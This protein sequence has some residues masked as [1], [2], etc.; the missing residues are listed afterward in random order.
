MLFIILLKIALAFTS[1]KRVSAMRIGAKQMQRP[2][3][4]IKTAE[5]IT[6]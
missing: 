6:I 1:A 5:D 2:K 3:D 4:L